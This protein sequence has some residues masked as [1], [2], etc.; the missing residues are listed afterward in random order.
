MQRLSGE[1][2]QL[3]QRARSKRGRKSGSNQCRTE[4][5]N[6]GQ[7]F[8]LTSKALIPKKSASRAGTSLSVH[9]FFLSTEGIKKKCPLSRRR[10]NGLPIVQPNMDIAED[11]TAIHRNSR[12]P[13]PAT[14]F[15]PRV[16]FNLICD[17][18][19]TPLVVFTPLSPNFHPLKFFHPIFTL[20]AP[21]SGI[22]EAASLPLQGLN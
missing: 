10:E 15:L 19:F 1:V 21:T 11:N 5:T 6:N 14:P 4:R 22:F 20:S 3:H 13:K 9:S 2:L 8:L 7:Q 18:I 17:P 16:F 12:Q